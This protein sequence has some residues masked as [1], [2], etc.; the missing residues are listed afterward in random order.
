[1]CVYIAEPTYSSSLT[2]TVAVAYCTAV[3]DMDMVKYG[4]NWGL[5]YYIT[6][7]KNSRSFNIELFASVACTVAHARIRCNKVLSVCNSCCSQAEWL[8]RRVSKLFF[9]KF[10]IIISY[11]YCINLTYVGRS[12]LL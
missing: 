6:K 1:V 8:G 9:F 11:Y 5:Y 7:Y 2:H 3:Q 12:K 10:I 4:F